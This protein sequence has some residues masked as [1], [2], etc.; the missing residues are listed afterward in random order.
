V[1]VV[2]DG[3][4]L[5]VKGYGCADLEHGIPITPQTLF[6]AASLA[7][8]F[9]AFAILMLEA[10]KKLS[11]DDGVRLAIRYTL[12]I[13]DS[14]VSKIFPGFLGGALFCSRTFFVV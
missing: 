4:P 12:T 10:Q 2:F 8:Q 3:K 6:N 9:A 5:L 13:L 11:L 14:V 7:K 1:A